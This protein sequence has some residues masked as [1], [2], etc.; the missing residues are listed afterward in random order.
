[1]V[2]HVAQ[3]ALQAGL[4]PVVVVTGAHAF[5]VEAV[6]NDLPVILARNLDWEQGQSTSL[7]AGLRL[8]SPNTGA[9]IF[10]LTDQPQV[11]VDLIE[12]L[13]ELHSTTLSPIVAPQINGRRGTPMLFDRITFPQLNKLS[14]DVGGRALLAEDSGYS[15]TWLPWQNPDLLLDVDEPADYEQLLRRN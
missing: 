3:V 15:I 8:L 10:L 14:G 7:Q 9:A 2:R 6:V 4:T 12:A 13:I 11:S 5:E 1:M